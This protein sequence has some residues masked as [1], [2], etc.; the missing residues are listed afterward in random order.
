MNYYNPY[1]SYMPYNMMPLAATST[2]TRGILGLLRGG[3]RLGSGLNWA[4]ILSNTQKTL[5]IVNQ[6]IPVVRQITPV[7][8]NAKTMFRVMNEFKKVD[9]QATSKAAPQVTK[10]EPV[11]LEETKTSK[12]EK[13]EMTNENNPTFFL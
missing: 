5:G 13:V 8:R 7:V 9:T 1:F 12:V 6:A 11:P 3:S 10:E 4:G 2:P